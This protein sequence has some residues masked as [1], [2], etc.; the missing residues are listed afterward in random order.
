MKKYNALLIFLMVNLF[1]HAQSSQVLRYSQEL[2]AQGQDPVDFVTRALTKTDLLIFDDALHSAYEPFVFYNQLINSKSLAGKIDFIF[3]ETI[4]TTAQPAID[5]FLNGKVKDSTL[6]IKAFQDD[7]TGTGWNL[8][9]Y[10]DLFSTVWEHN[11]LVAD[12][13]KIKIIGVNPPIYW[14]GIHTKQDYELFQNSLHARD[15]FMYLEILR[16][17][18]EFAN[19]K[20]GL[21]LTNTRHAYKNIRN[22]NGKLYWNTATFFS[23]W[24]PGNTLSVRIHNVTLSIEAVKNMTGKTRGELNEMNYRWIK[25]DNGRWDSAFALLGNKPV[26]ITLK[27]TNFGKTAYVGNHMLNVA[28]HTT[29]YD[30]YDALLFLAP[31]TNL[32]FSAQ[33]D[34]IY[35]PLFKPELE[36]RLR[37]LNEPDFNDLLKKNDATTFDDYFKK[38]FTS[39]PVRKNTLVKD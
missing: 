4:S 18:D 19:G 35:T 12:S 8:Q 14:E 5:N 23:Q 3:L 36:R 25:M 17:M 34:Y 15:Y 1:V 33:F 39:V 29:L 16:T 30:A 13:V 11:R 27:D 31:L 20:K 26:A 2:K 24:H 32:H 7:Y 37:L 9:T 28:R 6:L 38:E 22:A 10:L 21:F